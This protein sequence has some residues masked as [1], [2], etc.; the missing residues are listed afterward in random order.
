MGKASSRVLTTAV[1]I[2]D[3]CVATGAPEWATFQ[4]FAALGITELLGQPEIDSVK[5]V[6][7]PARS[8]QEIIRLDIAMEKPFGVDVF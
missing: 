2:V 5:H 4:I 3:T 8:H 1:V 6:P 7:V